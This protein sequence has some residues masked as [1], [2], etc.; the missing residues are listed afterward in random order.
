MN[1]EKR[2]PL[3]QVLLIFAAIFLALSVFL[4]VIFQFYI[5]PQAAENHNG[6]YSVNCKNY[7]AP[8]LLPDEP[9]TL[10]QSFVAKDSLS[11]YEI[12]IN[13]TEEKKEER[14]LKSANGAFVDVKGTLRVR[15]LDTDGNVVD[16]YALTDSQLNEALYFGR[17]MHNFDSLISGNVRGQTFTLEITGNFPKNSGIYLAASDYDYYKDGD[18]TADGVPLQKDLAFYTLSPIYTMARL[19]FLAF[20]VGL[21]AAF[22]IVYFC[23]Y[24]FR[25]KK[26]TLFFVTVLV[27]GIGYTALI[28]PFAAPDETV[29][30]YTAY[31]FANAVTF[32]EKTET[33]DHTVYVRACDTDYNGMLSN[34]YGQNYLPTVSTYAT[35]INNV[36]GVQENEEQIEYESDFTSGNYVCYAA[37]GFGIAIAKVLR[38]PSA[39]TMYFGRLMNLLLFAFLGACA[40][41]KMPF[42]KNIFFVVALLPLTL[43]QAA[44][45]SYDSVIIAF[46]FYYLA[47]CMYLA[48]TA[49][50]I[51]IWDIVALVICLT[52]FCAPKAGVY[53]VLLALLP[54]VLFNPKLQKKQKFGL[55]GGAA[56]CA[57]LCLVAFNA[58]RLSGESSAYSSP[59]IPKYTLGYIFTNTKD[60]IT[61]LANTYFTEKETWMYSLFG[62][63]MAWVNLT[64]EKTWA[65]IFAT[66]LVAGGIRYTES[67][68][69]QMR[70]IDKL[71][72]AT[73][74]L[75]CIAGFSAAAYL[76][77]TTDVTFVEGLQTRYILPALPMLLLLFRIPAVSWRKDITNF[78]TVAMVVTNALYIVDALKV[79]LLS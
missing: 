42:G 16:D 77:T 55:V 59:E 56:L 27:M 52:V 10:R 5:T 74:V 9:F 19:L 38:L 41:K 36:L 64:V 11:G 43:Q 44:S 54:I 34:F 18:L 67:L 3:W 49:E 40:V 2:R 48:Y 22:T 26:H 60:F 28:T 29:H 68:E 25:V 79:T 72:L 58:H 30:Y 69:P 33:P 4:G 53:I 51:R 32:T 15:L 78:L 46:A 62:S 21:L 13:F 45:F 24:V 57:L 12:F 47:L 39:L 73:A 37:A 8:Y 17:I 71:F 20:S 76:W 6:Y 75:L 50:K 61:L 7:K 35:A 66:L 70:K 23:A 1:T 14:A 63:D 65:L 31:R